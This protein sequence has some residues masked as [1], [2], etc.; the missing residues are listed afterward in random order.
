MKYIINCGG[1]YPGFKTPRHLLP[2]RGERIIERTI[3][4]LRENGVTDIS[5]SATDPRFEGL[6]VPVLKPEKS[7]ICGVNGWWIDN[8]FIETNEPTCYIFGDVIFSP[9]AIKKIVE[10]ETDDVE[11]FA[12]APPFGAGY[13]KH[14]AEPFA[15]KVVNTEHFYEAIKQTKDLFEAHL[16]RRCIAWEL[17]QV[18]KDTELNVIDYTNYTAINDY[19]CD[20][21]DVDDAEFLESRIKQ[22]QFLIEEAI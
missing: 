9:A 16:I 13:P 5:I 2:L 19:T 12:S 15:F 20:I 10:T 21:D 17:W 4:L 11:F 6:G 1:E 8:A 7:Y 14:H 3:R 22:Y 18:I